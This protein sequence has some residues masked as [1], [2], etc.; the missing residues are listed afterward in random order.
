MR[1][2]ETVLV[3]LAAANHDPA[4]NPAPERFDIARERPRTFTFGAGVHACPG[5]QL[6]TTI[7]RAGVEQLIARG[8]APASLAETVTYRPSVNARIPLFAS[9]SS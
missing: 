9:G 8:I 4:A 5:E 2:G 6:T 7:A 1:A 3:V